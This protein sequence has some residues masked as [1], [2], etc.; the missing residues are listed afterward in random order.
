MDTTASN[1]RLPA[2][3]IFALLA[4]FGTAL[5]MGLLERYGS[6]SS[7]E[8]SDTYASLATPAGYTFSIWGIVFAALVVFC[9]ASLDPT[10]RRVALFDRLSI[11]IV[12]MSILASAW[13]LAFHL[14]ELVLSLVVMTVFVGVAAMAF[15]VAHAAVNRRES[16]VYATA[17]F[18]LLLGWL[19]VAAVA[20]VAVLA[21]SLGAP[22]VGEGPEIVTLVA[23][24]VL[25]LAA[26]LV[27]SRYADFVLPGAIGWG[28]FGILVARQYDAPKVAVV[29]L[30]GSLV[31]ASA[32]VGAAM[33]RIGDRVASPKLGDETSRPRAR[34]SLESLHP[35][36]SWV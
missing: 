33:D 6:T 17:P 25:T 11:P 9:L 3:R 10:N 19:A 8:V 15:Q 13:V 30:F 28:M 20:N 12:S 21:V 36:D 23:L 16:A 5:F 29:A 24:G 31:V 32:A 26:S 2:G 18:S 4:V 22:S 1:D 34:P 7:R 14:H 27:A 35:R